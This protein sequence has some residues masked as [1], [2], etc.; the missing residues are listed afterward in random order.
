MV[1]GIKIIGRFTRRY[2]NDCKSHVGGVVLLRPGNQ[3]VRSGNSHLVSHPSPYKFLASQGSLNWLLNTGWKYLVC[4]YLLYF[5]RMKAVIP[6]AF[7][8]M[9]GA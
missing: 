2:V 6:S 9:I 7:K 8:A 5:V 1:H 4:I 3:T